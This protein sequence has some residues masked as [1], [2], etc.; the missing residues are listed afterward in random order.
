[1]APRVTRLF[2]HAARIHHGRIHGAR[3]DA[4]SADAVCADQ[5]G[6]VWDILVQE[7]RSGAAAKR[8][9]KHLL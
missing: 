9:F 7:R 1:M 6:A 8:F 2:A 5:H 3:G 4:V